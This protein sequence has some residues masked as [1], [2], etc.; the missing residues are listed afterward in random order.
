MDFADP[1]R[2]R[3]AIILAGGDGRRLSSYTRQLTGRA[4][5]KQFCRLIGRTTLLR[6]TMERVSLIID[7]EHT[8]MALT[9]AH[10]QYY[11]PLVADV[12]ARQLVIQP[13]NRDTAPA[14]LYSLARD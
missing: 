4:T 7:A 10:E 3:W 6:Q 1:N 2:R 14:I 5:P 9:R 12:P 8:L 13:E 11:A